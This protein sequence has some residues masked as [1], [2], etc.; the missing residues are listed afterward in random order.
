MLQEK[1]EGM[2][3]LEP[4]HAGGPLGLD[5]EGEGRVTVTKQGRGLPEQRRQARFKEEVKPDQEL[6]G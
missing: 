1:T 2:P 4:I 6:E 5:G 3:A